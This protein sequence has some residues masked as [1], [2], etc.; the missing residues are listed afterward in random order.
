MF[1]LKM[2]RGFVSF[3]T[4]I[5]MILT[6]I[7]FVLPEFWHFED[8]K[9]SN[10]WRELLF[11]YL[12]FT[13][14]IL[15]IHIAFVIVFSRC[16]LP[17]S[18]LHWNWVDIVSGFRSTLFQPSHSLVACLKDKQKRGEKNDIL[19]IFSDFICSGWMYCHTPL[20]I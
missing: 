14:L 9:P 3:P 13:T 8:L 7:R 17:P 4:F 5:Q 19:I 18:L 20:T 16:F 6:E 1:H 10:V 11:T 15:R 2:S 12:S